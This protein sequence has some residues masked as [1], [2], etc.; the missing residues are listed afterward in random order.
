MLHIINIHF[1]YQLLFKAYNKI[2]SLNFGR[3]CFGISS[4]LTVTV[5]WGQWLDGVVQILE[6]PREVSSTAL[7]DMDGAS[8]DVCRLVKR[9]YGAKI[10][11]DT[12]GS[13]CWGCEGCW[14]SRC[15]RRS[16]FLW[17]LLS[18]SPQAKGLYPV[19]FLMCVIRLLLWENDL[20]Q[21]THLWG[22]SPARKW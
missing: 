1:Q 11:Q 17:N 20:P 9:S 22:F 2:A 3:I 13:R 15:L 21:T 19:C 6:L 4:V 7:V 8:K 14:E 5:W 16:T 18:Q 10:N 12:E